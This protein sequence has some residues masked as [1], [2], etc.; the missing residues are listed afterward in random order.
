MDGPKTISSTFNTLANL[1]PSIGV[2]RN[3]AWY[4]DN[5]GNGA[6]EGCQTDS[7]IASFGGFKTDIP[8]T[9][10]WTG[11]GSIKVGI[12]RNGKWY[13]DLNGNG[14]WEDCQTDKCAPSFGGSNGDVPVVGDWTGDKITKLGI[15]RK[16]Q[17][18]LDKNGNGAWDGCTVDSC[19][20]PFGGFSMDIPIVGNWTGDG[21]MKIGI[22]RQG[23]WFL[24]KNGN[25][26]WEGCDVDICLGP[27]GGF[28]EDIPVIGDWDHTGKDKIGIYRKG[29]WFLD[30][31]D[32]GK[33][34][35]C[36]T[37]L[38]VDALGGFHGDLPVVA[39]HP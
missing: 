21:V 39:N 29:H 19:L 10:D 4:F 18:Y 1:Y 30:L 11:D 8:V 25:G 13:L 14:I 38:C 17:W 34:D 7:C 31:T 28:K 23:Q 33:W 12:Y 27:F 26:T 2:F 36:G 9:G 35:G 32:N 6:W 16:G 22:Y 37:D 15:Y 3:G 24:D 5:N 20:G